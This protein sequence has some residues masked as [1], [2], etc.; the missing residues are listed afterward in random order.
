M[1]SLKTIN[2]TNPVYVRGLLRWTMELLD[3]GPSGSYD[4]FRTPR[5]RHLGNEIPELDS[6]SDGCI[7]FQGLEKIFRTYVKI[8]YG[9]KI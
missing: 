7:H 3:M 8:P 6:E 5:G 2:E 9:I 1:I 4:V